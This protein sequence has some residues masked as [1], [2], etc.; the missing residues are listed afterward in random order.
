MTSKYN[1]FYLFIILGFAFDV[2]D[3]TLSEIIASSSSVSNMQSLLN[4]FST[5]ADENNMQINCTKTKEMI[6][7]S[8]SKRDWP[9]LTIHGT[10]LERVSVDKLLGAFISA[11][12]RWETHTEYIISKAASRLYFLKQ[13]KRAGLSS[14]HL[15]H[16]YI[17]VIRPVLE[18]AS[19]LWHPT[20]TKS[21]IECLEAVQ[22]RAIKIIFCYSSST[23]YLTTLELAGILSLQARRVDLSKRLFRNICRPD[24]SL[25][26]LLPPPRDIA[27]TSR[28]RKP[29]VYPRPSLRTKRYCSAVSYALLNFQ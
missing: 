28:L 8:T 2:D 15:L 21:Q 1:S 24:N 27:V 4:Q 16:F 6:L 11:D 3:T 14:S 13:L 23:S 19:P 22:R 25:Y 12:L 29:T 9:V 7:G 17:T 10:P 26:H 5:C 18:Y 20:L